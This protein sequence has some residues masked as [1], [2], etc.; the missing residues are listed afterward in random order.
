MP[1]VI[2]AVSISRSYS[3]TGM[4][5]SAVTDSRT[6]A[7]NRS[8]KASKFSTLMLSPAAYLCPPNCSTKSPQASMAS[9]M[10][11]VLMLRALP[12]SMPSFREKTM[13]GL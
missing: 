9:W 11:K 13:V 6:M 1:G 12:V 10:S 2:S 3:T 4:R 8:A 7:S 5:S